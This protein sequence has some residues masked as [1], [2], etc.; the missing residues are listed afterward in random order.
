MQGKTAVKRE[1]VD[2]REQ[3]V[4]RREVVKQEHSVKRE[5][6]DERQGVKQ[7]QSVQRE[8]GV[9]LEQGIRQE[10]AKSEPVVKLQPALTKKEKQNAFFARHNDHDPEDKGAGDEEDIDE[11]DEG[12]E[13]RSINSHRVDPDGHIVEHHSDSDDVSESE[14]GPPLIRPYWAVPGIINNYP[15]HVCDS[16]CRGG[17]GG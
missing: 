6:V 4:K 15:G 5:P 2:D 14:G 10:H 12:D 16:T 3:R 7:E 17:S 13:N 11:G 9:K 1:S 8:L